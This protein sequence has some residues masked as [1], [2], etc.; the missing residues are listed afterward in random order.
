MRVRIGTLPCRHVWRGAR[1]LCK[2]KNRN[3]YFLS[4]FLPS[5][6]PVDVLMK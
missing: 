4:D 5:S 2:A 6:S 1:S 3:R